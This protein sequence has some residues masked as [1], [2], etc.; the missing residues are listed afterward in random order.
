MNSRILVAQYGTKHGHAEGVLNVMLGNQD[1]EVKGVFE[2]DKERVEFLRSKNAY[3]WN[4]IQFFE[5]KEEILSDPKVL[6]IAS[7]GLN[8]ESLSYTHEILKSGKHVFY[9]KPAGDNLDDFLSCVDIARRN[10]LLI[11]M[12]YMFRNHDGFSKISSIVSRGQIGKVFQIRAN[13][14]TNLVPN[15]EIPISKHQGGIL[16]DLGG[17]MIDQIV[18][19]LGV[20]NKIY[21]FLRR[22]LS[23]QKNYQDNTLSVFEYDQAIATIDINSRTV[24]YMKTR[25]FEVYGDKGSLIL[26]PFEPAKIL[27]MSLKKNDKTIPIDEEYYSELI[28]IEDKPRYVESFDS[29]IKAI[30][31]EKK[32]DRTFEHEIL[33]QETLLRATNSAINSQI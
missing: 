27:R 28:P 4:Q 24:N 11:Q 5:E 7:E 32:P 26:E 1:V 16:Y 6:A 14:S 17:H 9:D 15:D 20:P 3:P 33:V 8:K 22:D 30:K 19:L 13:M 25:R 21:T 29:F 10:K 12:G 2:P 23:K 18:Y 31:G